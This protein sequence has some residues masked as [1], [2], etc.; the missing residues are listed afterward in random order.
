MTNGHTTLNLNVMTPAEL[1]ALAEYQGGVIA[2][3]EG[4]VDALK[5]EIAE[6]VR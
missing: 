1:R 6:G 5:E 2:E 3:L 4:T